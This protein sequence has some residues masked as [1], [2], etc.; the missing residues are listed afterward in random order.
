MVSYAAIHPFDT[1]KSIVQSDAGAAG[2][3]SLRG[4]MQQHGIAGLYRGIG[5]VLL[6]AVPENA[7]LLYTYELALHWLDPN[8]RG[9]V[10][11]AG[12]E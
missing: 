12:F 1:I 11:A 5:P 7:A 6:Q 10:G 2:V 4:V 8:A 9:A 3:Q